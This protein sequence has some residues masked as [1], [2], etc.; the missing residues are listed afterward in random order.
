M[1]NSYKEVK[2]QNLGGKGYSGK[3]VQGKSPF[4]L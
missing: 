4:L 1:K 2:V 3:A